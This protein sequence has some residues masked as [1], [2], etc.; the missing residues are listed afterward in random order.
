MAV[1]QATQLAE[2]SSG[3]G[4]AGAI[5][6]VD[7]VNNK[8][9]IGT[10]N[11]QALLQVGDIIKMDG[12]SGVITA[13]SFVG[14]VTGVST[15]LTGTPDITVGNIVAA[16]ATFSGVVTYEDV[17]NV[18]S[19]GIVTA[20]TGLEVTANGL[21]INAGVSTFAADLS[22]ADK[23]VHT[24][25]TNTAIRFPSADTFTVE[26]SGVERFRVDSTGDVGLVGIATATGLVVVAGSGIY[27][28]H[29]G[30][31][32]AVSFDGNV[33]GN[34][35]GTHTGA[36]DLNG[37]VLTLDADAD[38]T[39]TADTD[40]QIDI[41]FGGND[42]ITLS[43][44]LIDLKNDGSQSAIRLYCESSNAH[45]AALQAP[46]HSA[47]SGNITLTLPATTDTLV[48]RTTTD[49]L[50]NKTLTDPSI[51]DKIIHSGDTNTAIR[52]PAADTFT[53]ETSGS[54]ALRVDS[55]GRLGIGTNNP[56]RLLHLHEES[57]D[58]VLLSFTN[59]TT[60]VT[61]GDGAVFGIQDNES[62]IISN[63]ENN[64]IELHTN[65]T[66][67]LRITSAG[68]VSIQNDSGKFTAGAGD[69]L[70]IYHDGS[71]SYFTN[72]NSG[73]IILRNTVDD[74]DIILQTDNGSGGV[75]TYIL[76]DGDQET[77]RLYYQGNEKLNT[78]SDGVDITGEL[79]CDSLDVDGNGDISGTTTFGAIDVSSTSTN[80]VRALGGSGQLVIQRASGASGRAIEI[81]N[82]STRTID[83]FA[84]GQ[85]TFAGDVT[86]TGTLN[87]TTDVQINGTSAA[88]TGKAIAMSMIFG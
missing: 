23:I 70:Q 48:A 78:K 21:V 82:G 71:H 24:G 88:T 40:D 19:L 13:T 1:T 66:E 38:T 51:T 50:T 87:A 47:F 12:V 16:G 86:V 79:Q 59:T 33:T 49:T 63:K 42:R 76:C 36:V 84:N 46:A 43:T 7:N 3:I 17:T 73:D 28:G 75:A 56:A 52:F 25:D 62:I 67:R 26:T 85:A 41:A 69:D 11:P 53:V 83:I 72:E 8:I 81:Y 35:S 5:L 18:D 29:A 60:G 57:S 10:T 15:G 4:T 65:N 64:H 9:G 32:T 20:R 14:N 39:I 74:E 55:S 30:V 44:G 22:M 2:F 54:E 80:G 45:Y 58:G 27:A 6:E 37:G 34:S 61:G 77:V 68:N 31:I